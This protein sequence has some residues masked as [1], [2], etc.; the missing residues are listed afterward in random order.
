MSPS[1]ATRSFEPGTFTFS[2]RARDSG[3]LYFH[4]F[5]IA[6]SGAFR[7]TPKVTLRAQE[8][9]AVLAKLAEISVDDLTLE[10]DVGG[11]LRFSWANELGQFAVCL[12][13]ATADGSLSSRRLQQMSAPTLAVSDEDDTNA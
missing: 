13:T 4:F 8:F 7:A 5:T 3:W 2:N 11:L 1:L 9:F 12:P 10:V 6:T